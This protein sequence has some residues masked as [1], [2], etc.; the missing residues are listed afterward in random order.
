MSLSSFLLPGDKKAKAKVI[1]KGLDD[2]FRSTASVSLMFPCS[3]FPKANSEQC[4]FRPHQ[5]VQL[6][7]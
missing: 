3:M 4:I 5:F 2:L 7:A 1:D 6:L